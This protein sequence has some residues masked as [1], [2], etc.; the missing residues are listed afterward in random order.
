MDAEKID[1]V[2]ERLSAG[3]GDMELLLR[4]IC[5]EGR[6]II[7]QIPN[8]QCDFFA[9]KMIHAAGCLVH[10]K[11]CYEDL[12]LEGSGYWRTPEGQLSAR[13]V[14]VFVEERKIKDTMRK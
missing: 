7:G 12:V 4:R 10:R 13:R 6:K 1:R 14:S 11:I 8:E 9:R 2:V 5:V 3:N